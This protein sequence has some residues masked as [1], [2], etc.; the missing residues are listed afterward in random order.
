LR[1][2]VFSC[3]ERAGANAGCARHL[4]DVLASTVFLKKIRRISYDRLFEKASERKKGGSARLVPFTGNNDNE[5]EVWHKHCRDFSLQN[6]IYLLSTK[7]NAQRITDLKREPW[8][9]QRIMVT[10]NVEQRLLADVMQP[11]PALRAVADLAASMDTTLWFDVQHLK[12]KRP[13]ALLATGQF[14]TCYN[15]LRY[16]FRFDPAIV[17]LDFFLT[18]ST[19]DF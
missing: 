16:A 7:N 10:V 4:R 14:T 11:S 2:A 13:E 12:D 15:L 6:A 17:T 8:Y 5:E 3:A 9:D 19:G 1:K 18:A